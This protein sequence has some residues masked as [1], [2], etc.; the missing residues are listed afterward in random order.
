[1]AA[2]LLGALHLPAA[3]TDSS[4]VGLWKTY[5]DHTGQQRGTVLIYERDGEYFG[6]IASSVN[7]KDATER[8]GECTDDRK[9]QLFIGI[10]I[11][12][13]LK[14]SGAEYNGGTILDP[15]TGSIYRCRF[16]LAEGG[17]KL[18]LRGYLGIS[19]L[20]RTQTWLRAE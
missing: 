13:N 2:L 4:P 5:D 7:P 1:M 10:E 20:G 19:L 3:S 12:R 8:C 9:G 17:R 11:L 15:D 18:Q 14:L 16:R 6:R